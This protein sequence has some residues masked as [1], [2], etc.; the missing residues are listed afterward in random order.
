MRSASTTAVLRLADPLRDA[1]VPRPDPGATNSD[2]PLEQFRAID[3][4]MLPHGTRSWRSN[5]PVPPMRPA[6]ALFSAALA[7]FTFSNT[8]HRP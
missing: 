4:P 8:D 3:L 5:I 6:N 2:P 1:S 7:V